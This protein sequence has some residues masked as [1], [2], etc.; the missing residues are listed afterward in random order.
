MTLIPILIL[1]FYFSLVYTCMGGIACFMVV[2][3]QSLKDNSIIFLIG[4]DFCF[5]FLDI[6]LAF[7]LMISVI[8]I[9][10]K[11]KFFVFLIYLAFPIFF[12]HESLSN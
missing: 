2:R 1:L 12:L 9:I 11:F 5:Y 8:F 6:S 7:I 10:F 4:S 3:F